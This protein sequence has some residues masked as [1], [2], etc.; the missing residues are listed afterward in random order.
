MK[1]ALTS[2]GDVLAKKL[3]R[4]R[5]KSGDRKADEVD[6]SHNLRYADAYS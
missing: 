3:G 6:L 5:S 1:A 2:I 4:A